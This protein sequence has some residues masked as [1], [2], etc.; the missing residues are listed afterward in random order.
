M[1]FIKD[2]KERFTGH[3]L[4][5][6]FGK[7]GKKREVHKQTISTFYSSDDVCI[8]SNTIRRNIKCVMLYNFPFNRLKKYIV[9]TFACSYYERAIRVMFSFKNINKEF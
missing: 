5:E 2:S 3:I 8:Q 4:Q 9:Y 6:L 1:N 7:T